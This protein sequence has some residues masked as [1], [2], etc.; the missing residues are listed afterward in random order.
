MAD[1]DGTEEKLG[2]V[3]LLVDEAGVLVFEPDGLLA[4]GLIP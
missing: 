1:P 4:T 2:I 3:S